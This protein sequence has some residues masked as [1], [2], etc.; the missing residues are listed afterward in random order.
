MKRGMIF[1]VSVL[2]VAA[3]LCA[4]AGRGRKYKPTHSVLPAGA[5]LDARSLEVLAQKPAEIAQ[6]DKAK[7]F[8]FKKEQ[9]CRV[10]FAASVNKTEP[11]LFSLN[12]ASGMTFVNTEHFDV[13]K[14]AKKAKKN[15][16][17]DSD[18]AGV[19]QKDAFVIY[20]ADTIEF[21][22]LSVRGAN[23]QIKYA[24]TDDKDVFDRSVL[25]MCG[26][27]GTSVLAPLV[28][29]VDYPN[30]EISFLPPNLFVHKSTP[31]AAI[32][33]QIAPDKGNI[34]YI[35]LSFAN[36]KKAQFRL[37]TASSES[38]LLNDATALELDLVSDIDGIYS[39]PAVSAAGYRMGAQTA[40][41]TIQPYNT[42][43]C[44]LFQKYRM[45]LD[46]PARKVYLEES[47]PSKTPGQPGLP[48]Q[49]DMLNGSGAAPV[50]P[51]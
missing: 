7:P 8:R 46:Y 22:G 27:I 50:S 37:D 4:C 47:V 11:C 19:V 3:L 5:P 6:A 16:I 24:D 41:R 40:S 10:L 34:P 33:F 14:L 23:F 17:V 45:V 32:P 39:I 30:S 13:D 29:S 1:R 38:L 21:G 28:V 15:H 12:T 43:G 49:Y 2:V 18:Q 42:A 44:G 26:G 36:G 31:V 35:E 51:F 20:R 48:G 25:D 9:D